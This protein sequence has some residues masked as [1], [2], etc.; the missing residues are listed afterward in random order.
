[1]PKKKRNKKIGIL[2]LLLVVGVL[3]GV[4]VKFYFDK[5]ESDNNSNFKYLVVDSEQNYYLK[6]VKNNFSIEVK[7]EKDFSYEVVD[8]DGE[9]VKTKLEKKDKNKIIKPK[10]KYKEGEVYTL[11]IENGSFV[12]QELKD[13]KTITFKVEREESLKFKLKDN[14]NYL[15]DKKATVKD[16]VLTTKEDYEVDDIIIVDN[17][18]AYK[19]VK[20][21]YDNTYDLEIPNIDE[22]YD[23]IDIYQEEP[24][25]LSDFKASDDFKDYLTMVVKDSKWYHKLVKEVKAA[26]EIGLE[27][28]TSKAKKGILGVSLKFTIPAGDESN[29]ITIL[30][31][32]DLTFEVNFSIEVTSNL[33][34]TWGAIDAA[35]NVKVTDGYNFNIDYVDAKL[36]DITTVQ[37]IEN[38][39]NTFNVEDL[40]FDQDEVT[41]LLG[42]TTVP[43][44]T[45]GFYFNIDL[46]II[47]DYNMA[48]DAGYKV[49]NETNIT[50]GFSYDKDEGFNPYGSSATKNVENHAYLS[51][52]ASV[53]I[54]M[55]MA[56]GISFLNIVEAAVGVDVGAYGDG[57]L[58]VI[59]TAVPDGTLDYNSSL[60][61]SAEIGLFMDAN[62]RFTALDFK[63]DFDLIQ[64]K[65]PFFKFN[66][67]EEDESDDKDKDKEDKPVSGK[68]EEVSLSDTKIKKYYDIFFDEMGQYMTTYVTAKS[69]KYEDLSTNVKFEMVIK[70][71]P[72]SEYK[73]YGEY[74]YRITK[75][76]FDKYYK[77]AFGPKATYDEA[78]LN[79]KLSIMI[80]SSKDTLPSLITHY[81]PYYTYDSKLKSFIYHGGGVGDACLGPGDCLFN[82]SKLVEAYK[83]GDYLYIVSKVIAITEVY[84][85]TADGY[86]I[87]LD[88]AKVY[89]DVNREKLITDKADIN[90]GNYKEYLDQGSTVTLVLKKQSDSEDYYFVESIVE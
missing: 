30:E 66:Y 15:V 46:G 43:I 80:I 82:N 74:E 52:E 8:S 10:N 67:P 86:D 6:K 13:T 35:V 37:D 50:F 26:P 19:I 31:N 11:T 64:L 12:N 22:L 23:D 39:I 24:V 78:V 25:D 60:T 83:E 42:R 16:N 87:K 45:T 63:K 29:F 17:K 68:K 72:E 73:P 51:G 4:G 28:D 20:N 5:K 55:D 61:V 1:M 38:F 47:F 81:S 32:H 27:F 33:D 18:A 59:A 3:I 56:M 69:V 58:E 9:I 85:L 2:I 88:Q 65:D 7:P 62:I 70:S 21:N 77:K 90:T 79:D 89:K 44:G 71:I 48:V 57:S 53:K 40:D 14:V 41:K 76:V 75:E 84:T 36:E 54:G 34:W 49:K